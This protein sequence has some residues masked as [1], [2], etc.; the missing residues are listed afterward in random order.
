MKVEV[1]PISWIG[2][3]HLIIFDIKGDERGSLVAIEGALSVPFEIRRVYYIFGTQ[4]GVVRGCHAH[5]NLQ[6]VAICVRGSCRFMLDDGSTRWSV[7]LDRPDQGLVIDPMVWH[8]MSNFS[9]D[10][11]L[12]VLASEHYDDADYIRDF[13]VFMARARQYVA[14]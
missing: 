9:A 8:E 2:K 3:N 1:Q 10:C 6:Q 7:T 13:D 4:P 14:I 11:V 12:T 5:S